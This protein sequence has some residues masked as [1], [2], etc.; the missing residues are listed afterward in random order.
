MPV[1]NVCVVVNGL[2]MDFFDR[3]LLQLLLRMLHHG[4]EADR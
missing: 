1:Y 3:V 2:L 4:E